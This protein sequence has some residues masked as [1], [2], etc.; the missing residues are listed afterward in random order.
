MSPLEVE[1]VGDE[2]AYAVVVDVVNPMVASCPGGSFVLVSMWDWE[3]AMFISLSLFMLKKRRRRGEPRTPR[4]Q[5]EP[6]KKYNASQRTRGRL[7][8]ESM[9]LGT[10]D[11]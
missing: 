8:K 10:Q 7:G 4:D 2:V 6:T 11:W 5:R 3:P 1:K 9:G